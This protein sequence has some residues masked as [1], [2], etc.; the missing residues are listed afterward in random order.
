MIRRVTARA[1]ANIALVKYWGK[2]PAAAGRDNSPATPS[3]ALALD[4]LKTETIIERVDAPGDRFFINDKPADASS[5]KRLTEYIN[6]W[7]K[8]KL[9]DGHFVVSSQNNF[10]TRA[11]LASSSSGYAALAIAL[12]AFSK[13][14]LNLSQLSL[15][16][17]IGSGSAARSVTGGLSALPNTKNPAA[18]LIMP[19]GD[20]PWGMV[21][22]LT[23]EIEK[24][25]GSRQGMELSRKTSP[26]YKSWIDCAEKDYRNM[27]K[28][29]KRLDFTQIGEI[30]EANSLAMHSCMM[31][32]R[33]ALIYWNNATINILQAIRK[34]RNDGLETYATM[35]AGPHVAL[36]GHKHD[37]NRIAARAAK[38]AGVKA[39]IKCHPAVGA[40]IV[41]CH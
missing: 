22:A 31:A 15:L 10:P 34:W 8:Q 32:S 25:I 9:I 27:L 36:M 37:L 23:G 24:D 7:R 33:P 28:A 4:K 39:V 35:D 20:I 18:K 21:I 17:R 30:M 29:I 6:L 14:K 11:G 16:A 41:K 5:F 3:I 19:A 26:Y 40:G 38:V 12:S 1:F 13:R 2:Q